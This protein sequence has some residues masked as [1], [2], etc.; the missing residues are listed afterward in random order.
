MILLQGGY[1]VHALI[2]GVGTG[3][4]EYLM[5]KSGICWRLQFRLVGR[6]SRMEL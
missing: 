5:T 3:E 2:T 6:C 4:K 1:K